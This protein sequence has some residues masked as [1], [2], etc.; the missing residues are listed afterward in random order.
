MASLQVNS[1]SQ[2][3]YIDVHEHKDLATLGKKKKE[4]NS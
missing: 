2:N 3:S 1:T 4:K